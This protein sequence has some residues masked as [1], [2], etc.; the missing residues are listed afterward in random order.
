MENKPAELKMAD[1]T[2]LIK[3]LLHDSLQANMAYNIHQTRN[4]VVAKRLE[5]LDSYELVPLKEYLENI[6]KL[7][8]I[9]E[10]QIELEDEKKRANRYK[11]AA[12]VFEEISERVRKHPNNHLGISE[13][14]LRLL[15]DDEFIKL[16]ARYFKKHKEAAKEIPVK[17]KLEDF[18][19]AETMLCENVPK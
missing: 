18:P 3:S 14:D 7:E 4:M 2:N 11:A 17:N 8:K 9:E 15:T 6:E 5:Q 1:V 10:L 16:L 19:K 12:E 13:A